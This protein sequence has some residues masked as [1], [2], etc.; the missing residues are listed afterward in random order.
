MYLMGKNETNPFFQKHCLDDGNA[1]VNAGKSGVDGPDRS[2]SWHPRSRRGV[3]ICS[4]LNGSWS[5]FA[6]FFLNA[7]SR[8]RTPF[9][10][11]VF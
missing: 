10:N 7:R 6:D 5:I 1:S 9:F 4:N 11:G 2:S 8:R 3:V